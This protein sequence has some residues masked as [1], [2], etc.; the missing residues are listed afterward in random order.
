M[1]HGLRRLSYWLAF[2]SGLQSG[3]MRE[4]SQRMSAG[5]RGAS[6]RRGK[7]QSRGAQQH[8]RLDVQ[9]SIL[10]KCDSAALG[11]I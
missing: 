7:F 6:R 9:G 10:N 4:G 3:F 2:G 11:V 8:V 1:S 5:G